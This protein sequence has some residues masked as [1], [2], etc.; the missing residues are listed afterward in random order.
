[1]KKKKSVIAIMGP[2]ASGKTEL[3]LSLAKEIP[4][5]II[6]VD[7]ALIYR[8][9]DIGTAKPSI[10]ER[11]SIPHHLIDIKTPAESYSV[12]NFVDD[13][14]SLIEDIKNRNK[15]PI[16][17]GGTMMYFKS[18]I[19]GIN[20][21]PCAS[22][23]IRLIL[24]K[25]CEQ[26]GL[27]YLHEQ[28]AQVDTLSASRIHRNDKQRILRALEV[29]RLTG[30][31]LTD[32]NIENKRKMTIMNDVLQCTLK[33]EDRCLLHKRI[34]QRFMHMIDLGFEKEVL[35]LRQCSKLHMNLPSIRSVGYRQMW[36]YLDGEITY[37]DMID[38]SIAASRQLAKRQLTWLRNWGNLFSLNFQDDDNISK[39]LDQLH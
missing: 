35:H 22:Q 34:A 11:K 29:F 26:L 30:K 33:I 27:D 15:T 25:E 37:R 5:E 17:V 39:I 8:G 2:T 10:A 1:M 13:A 12:A 28:L 9:M 4:S 19:Y 31:S 14:L 24:E 21:L 38:K 20:D 16:L 32:L 6:S 18:L 7:S 23:D 3:A 36:S